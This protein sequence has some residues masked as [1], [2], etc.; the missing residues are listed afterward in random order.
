[1]FTDT[2][3]QYGNM[4]TQWAAFNAYLFLLIPSLNMYAVSNRLC[5]T[6]CTWNAMAKLFV[7]YYIIGVSNNYGHN[8]INIHVDMPNNYCSFTGQFYQL[9]VSKHIWFS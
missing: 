3:E 6:Y 4:H 5:K 1:M 9:D 8:S 2:D 7:L